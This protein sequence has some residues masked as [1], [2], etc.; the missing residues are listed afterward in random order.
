MLG[1]KNYSQEY[2]NQC[3]A[4]V[5]GDLRACRA[6]VAAAKSPAGSGKGSLDSAVNDHD[7]RFFN[8][9]ILLLDYFFVHRLRAI[10]GEDGNPL[11]EVR[12]LCNSILENRYVLRADKTIKLK[13]DTSVPKPKPGDAIALSEADFSRLSKAFFDE[14][15]R[16]FVLPSDL[17]GSTLPPAGEPNFFMDLEDSTHL[18]LFQFHVDFT[19]PSNSTFTGP[20]L[21]SVAPYSE[22]CAR[23]TTVACIPEAAPGEKVDGLADRLMFRLAYRNFGDH[24][25][26]VANHTVKGGALAGVRWYEI[27]N[28][29]SS[30]YVYQQETLVDPNTSFW[31]GSVAMDRMGD[32]A[33]GFS[34]SSRSLYPSIYIGGRTVTDP[35]GTMAGPMVM[36]NGTGA[37]FSSYKR[38]G[39]YSA[40]QW[41]RPTIARSG[42]PTSTTPQPAASTGAL[43]LVRSN[44]I[45]AEFMES[46]PK[47]D[48]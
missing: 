24:E 22:I 3:R 34:A 41:T 43:A 12:V 32:I 15:E 16:K 42:T 44:L 8:N 1:V 23:A 4:K 7:H 29:N 11:N 38:W 17:D 30:P 10:E 6:M 40:C 2:V 21:I 14:I 48:A 20:T 36:F 35:L 28:P 5:E 37:Q 18:N 47:S 46:R 39:D 27:R 25:S 45:P 19:N 31:L 13:P 33:L 26:L 9:M